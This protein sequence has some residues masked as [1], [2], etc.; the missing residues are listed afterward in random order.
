[1]LHSV[2]RYRQ[3]KMNAYLV[4]VSRKAEFDSEKTCKLLLLLLLS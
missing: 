1:M 2:L 4:L 3:K